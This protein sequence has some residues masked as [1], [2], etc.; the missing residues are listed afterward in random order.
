MNNYFC[1]F[2]VFLILSCNKK[3]DKKAIIVEKAKLQ[4]QDTT[5]S[6]KQ[7]FSSQNEKDTLDIPIGKINKYELVY[8][9][10]GCRETVSQGIVIYYK[11]NNKKRLL[12]K[13]KFIYSD[14]YVDEVSIFKF[15]KDNFIY[16]GTNHTYGHHQG[17]LYYLNTIKMKAYEVKIKP[18]FNTKIT[19]AADTLEF[20]KLIELTKDYKNNLG[21]GATYFVKESRNRYYCHCDYKITKIRKNKYILIGSDDICDPEN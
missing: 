1:I 5:L 14:F 12:L 20:H 2:I 10:I 6:K 19:K 16:I 7:S 4:T 17:Y 15:K 21:G 8:D 3:D 18:R 11:M 13:P 9:C